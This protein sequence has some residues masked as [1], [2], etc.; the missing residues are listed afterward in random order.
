MRLTTKTNFS[1]RLE[2][3]FFRNIET[4][5]WKVEERIP[6]EE[7]LVRTYNASRSTIRRALKH[8]ETKGLIQAVQG[9][10]RRVVSTPEKRTRSVGLF[11]PAGGLNSGIGNQYLRTLSAI[12]EERGCNLLIVTGDSAYSSSFDIS[13]FDGIILV[14]QHLPNEDIQRLSERIPLVVLGHEAPIASVPSYF[15]DYGAQAALATRFLLKRNHERIAITY[16]KK[17]YFY[18]A[19]YNMRKGYEWTLM[20]E[21]KPHDSGLLF[22]SELSEHGGRELYRRLKECRPPVTALIAFGHS[23]LIG[24]EQE[25][26]ASGEDLY[27]GLEIVCMNVLEGGDHL[28]RIHCFRCPYEEAARAA[29]EELLRRMGGT[30]PAE[31]IYHAY[32]GKL[33]EAPSA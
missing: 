11:F 5:V 17:S 33:V 12:M 9:M 18:Q 21:G 4:G 24:L 19:G 1:E 7:E 14:G 13:R 28:T 32:C 15:I 8:L 6:T 3:T 29:T 2:Q 23:T 27:D 25:A 26:E 16:G 20:L 31:E 10:G 22:V 30:A